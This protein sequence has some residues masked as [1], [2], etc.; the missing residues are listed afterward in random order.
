MAQPALVPL[1]ARNQVVGDL[2]THNG[3]VSPYSCGAFAQ[4]LSE[5]FP[6]Q[7]CHNYFLEGLFEDATA[8]EVQ[9][10]TTWALESHSYG[11][12]PL[13]AVKRQLTDKRCRHLLTTVNELPGGT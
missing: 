7:T 5:E 6:A 3:T 8:S 13:Y 2:I 1:F 9:Q 10:L 12:K 4:A 11:A